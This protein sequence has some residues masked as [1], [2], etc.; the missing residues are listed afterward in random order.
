MLNQLTSDDRYFCVIMINDIIAIIAKNYKNF[1]VKNQKVLK[2]INELKKRLLE[3]YHDRMKIFNFE[4]VNKLS[5]HR[6]II[7]NINLQ[8]EIIFS[9]KKIYELF[10]E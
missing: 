8:F 7:H 4:V 6:E 1:F 9:T 2:T 5:S 10:R 3:R